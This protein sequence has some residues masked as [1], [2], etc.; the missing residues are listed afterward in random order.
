[1][2]RSSGF[3]SFVRDA[4]VAVLAML[5]SITGRAEV[6]AAVADGDVKPNIIV[7]LADDL[8]IGTV[9]CYGSDNFKTPNVDA[10]AAGGVRF[11]TCYSAPNCGPS[12]ALMMTG[13]YGFRTGMTGNDKPAVAHLEAIRPPAPASGARFRSSPPTG[14]STSTSAPRGAAPT[15]PRPN[16]TPT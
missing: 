8:G 7:I 2:L 13:R 3:G 5:A 9:G 4:P 16:E 11:T 1:M 12:R 10:L 6:F 15:G 14:A